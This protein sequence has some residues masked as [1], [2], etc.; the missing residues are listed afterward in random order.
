M[1]IAIKNLREYSKTN[2]PIVEN[3]GKSLYEKIRD[4]KSNSVC[5]VKSV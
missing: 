2:N 1:D 5:L 3:N 4:W